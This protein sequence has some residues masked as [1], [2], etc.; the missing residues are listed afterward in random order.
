MKRPVNLLLLVVLSIASCNNKQE[1]TNSDNLP[2][3][4]TWESVSN[5]PKAPDF[6][7]DAKFGIYTHWGPVTVGTDHPDA[8]G[9]VQWYGKNMYKGSRPNFNYHI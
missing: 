5:Y 2:Y 7:L 8:G 6:F 1:S 9:G 3:Q 4:E